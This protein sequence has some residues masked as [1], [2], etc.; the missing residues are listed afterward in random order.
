MKLLDLKLGHRT[1][2]FSEGSVAKAPL[3]R[4]QKPTE[5]LNHPS[6]IV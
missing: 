6:V 5:A 4:L 1:I 3:D 2:F